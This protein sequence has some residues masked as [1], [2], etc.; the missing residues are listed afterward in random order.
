MT[1]HFE[2]HTPRDLRN[3]AWY[4]LDK[5]ILLQYGSK[6]KPSGIAVYSALASFADSKT[7]TCFPTQKAIAL[8]LGIS[9]KTVGRKIKLLESLLLIK[10]KRRSHGCVYL[11]LAL[12]PDAPKVTGG[13][14]K[15]ATANGTPGHTINNQLTR[16]NID[17]A[18][19]KKNSELKLTAIKG[20]KPS[21][22][23]ELLAMDLAQGLDDQKSLAHYLS[24]AK[25]L[26]E[27]LLRRALA[28][29][30][31]IPASK[32]KKSQAALFNH[33]IQKY[34]QETNNNPGG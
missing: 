5:R 15:G 8:I 22:P 26:P 32:I 24:L 7:Q 16:I 31:E 13:W 14:D 1:T 3:G 10:A 12:S 27:S 28:E 6:L 34:E 18:E 19:I 4:W 9:R 17:K 29:A 21:N 30:R 25:G 2:N 11:L 20:Y 33:L 23:Q